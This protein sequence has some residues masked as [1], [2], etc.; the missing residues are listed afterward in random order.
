MKKIYN[1]GILLISSIISYQAI[2]NSDLEYIDA[3]YSYSAFNSNHEVLHCN[4]GIKFYSHSSFKNKNLPVYHYIKNSNGEIISLVDDG[5]SGILCPSSETLENAY[6][7]STNGEEI[8]IPKELKLRKGD[9]PPVY[10]IYQSGSNFLIQS[11][12]WIN[13][14]SFSIKTDS[15][16]YIYLNYKNF[17]GDG[18]RFTSSV[19]AIVSGIEISNSYGKETY[20][21]QQLKARNVRLEL[22]HSESD[23]IMIGNEIYN[24]EVKY[25]DTSPIVSRD[26]I[27]IGVGKIIDDEL[28]VNENTTIESICKACATNPELDNRI[29]QKIKDGLTEDSLKSI[30]GISIGEEIGHI[31][32]DAKEIIDD[33]DGV[34]TGIK[35]TDLTSIAKSEDPWVEFDKNNKTVTVSNRSMSPISVAILQDGQ[36]DCS[37]YVS[38]HSIL[39]TESIIEPASGALAW[40]AGYKMGIY[41]K[42]FS[43]PDYKNN[44]VQIITPGGAKNEHLKFNTD[45]MVSLNSNCLNIKAIEDRLNDSEDALDE[46][47]E[48]SKKDLEKAIDAALSKEQKEKLN[49]LIDQY[50]AIAGTSIGQDIT[51]YLN[52]KY[53][54]RDVIVD[55]IRNK[56]DYNRYVENGDYFN[57]FAVSFPKANNAVQL[58][59]DYCSKIKEPNLTIR[60]AK[61]SL[62]AISKS[63]TFSKASICRVKVAALN[64]LVDNLRTENVDLDYAG[65][66]ANETLIAAISQNPVSASVSSLNNQM[67]K[68]N[69]FISENREMTQKAIAD[70]R[71]E[72]YLGAYETIN[73]VS[74]TEAIK[75]KMDNIIHKVAPLASVKINSIDNLQFDVIK[76]NNILLKGENLDL[77][78]A[79]FL[80]KNGDEITY[81]ELHIET[82]DGRSGEITVPS[83][84][85]STNNDSVS[86]VIFNQFNIKIADEI[87]NLF[88]SR[89]E[90]FIFRYKSSKLEVRINTNYITSGKFDFKVFSYNGNLLFQDNNVYFDKEKRIYGK[91]LSASQPRNEDY[92]QSNRYVPGFYRLQ[93]R[94]S[95]TDNWTELKQMAI[96]EGGR[97][98]FNVCN[99]SKYQEG[100]DAAYQYSINDEK[101]SISERIYI[102]KGECINKEFIVLGE[103]HFSGKTFFT[104]SITDHENGKELDVE[105]VRYMSHKY[106]GMIK[107]N[108][109]Y[110]KNN[111]FIGN[112]Y[113]NTYYIRGTNGVL[114]QIKDIKQ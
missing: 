24:P 112:S 97:L 13:Y 33:I 50:N 108:I 113:Y 82:S 111:I 12:D 77:A 2:S 32:T 70:I 55:L 22:E 103:M 86:I 51:E 30:L 57:A 89:Y 67:H 41:S 80:I 23:N 37:N 107:G 99:M 16:E 49:S 74:T 43:F 96:I 110:T 87:L 60:D 1:L 31:L 85:L 21:V 94:M 3:S 114:V 18:Y 106:Y 19:N 48:M 59:M 34:F 53:N 10:N 36:N 75:M 14:T 105:K 44:V 88:D 5:N 6:I 15:G 40:V 90:P 79:K 8:T 47:I 42:T 64:G 73:C 54:K 20:P 69:P 92:F 26:G 9:F 17:T 38:E 63:A 45:E 29:R 84:S 28:V 71:D 35:Q 56:D 95:G 102:N 65:R 39:G 58:Y 68:C 100:Q 91:Y 72:S 11:S 98:S 76:T 27:T 109:D 52:G 4:S 104:Q 101:G 83:E 61:N 78:K 93:Y 62:K 81:K 46:T 66:I 25:F 7:Y